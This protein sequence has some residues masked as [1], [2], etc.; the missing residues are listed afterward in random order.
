MGNTTNYLSTAPLITV[1]YGYRFTRWFQADAGFQAAFGAAHN[2]NAEVRD[3]G[4]VQSGD[5]EFMIPLGG[6]V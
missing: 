6:R 5:H 2:Q 1:G 3:L 4:P